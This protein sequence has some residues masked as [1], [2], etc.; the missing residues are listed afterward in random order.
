MTASS[1][2]LTLLL[3]ATVAASSADQPVFWLLLG[4]APLAAV[5]G[6]IKLVRSKVGQRMLQQGEVI[7][8]Q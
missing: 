3:I 7:S 2:L 8:N 4:P 5:I 1:F 6:M